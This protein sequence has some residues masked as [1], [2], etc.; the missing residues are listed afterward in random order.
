MKEIKSF[1]VLPFTGLSDHCCISMNI[2][3]NSNIYQTESQNGTPLA[4]KEVF[5]HPLT[6][7]YT[8]YN[9][10]KHIFKHNLL[11]DRNID[12]IGFMLAHQTELTTIAIDN[13][14]GIL[15]DALI[16]SSKKS[17][18]FRKVSNKIKP[19]R[20]KSKNW[21]TKE[22]K[23]R[24]TVLR[25]RSKALSSE[26]FSR[27]NRDLFVKARTAYKSTCRKAEREYRKSLTKQLLEIGKHD[28]K[29]FWNII[30]KMNNWGKQRSDPADNITPNRWLEHFRKLLNNTQM[31]VTAMTVEPTVTFEP[32]LDSKISLKE[33]QEALAELKT[34][35]A[36]GPD[37][38]LVEYLRV[39]AEAFE[40]TLL[41]L[42]NKIFS[43]YTYPSHWTVN[44]LKPI[45]K[46]GEK[47]DTDNF[48]GLAIGSAFAKLFSQ[49]LLKRLT[50][51]IDEKKLLSANQIGF[52]KGKSTSDHIFLL[53]TVI[54]KVVKKGKRKL[55][56]AFID[57]KKAYDTVDRD[58]L[59]KRLKSLGINGIFLKNIASMYE[60]T[61]YSIKLSKGYLAPLNSNLG[62]KQGCPLSPI[63]FNL[64]ID[65]IRYIF[66]EQ[67]DPIE[68]QGIH[69]SHFLYA[70]DLVIISN[71]GE[72]LQKSL[73]N[74]H[75]YSMK[76]SISIS[77][78][79]SKTMIFNLTGKLI[80]NYFTISGKPLEP[81]HTFCYLGFDFKA[82]GS[83]KYAAYVLHDKANKAM[84]SLFLAVAKFN[85][86]VKT[87]IKLFH[88]YIS[89]I[90]LYN[91]ENWSIL[92][93]KKIQNFSVE[94]IFHSIS[95][96]KADILHR[97]FL[98]YIIG[99]SKSCPNISVYGETNE[100]PLSLK[101][102]RLMINFWHRVTNLPEDT[103]VKKALLENIYLH[104]NWIK[105][106]EKLLGCLGLTD[107]I[108][109]PLT[110]RRR[111]ASA[112]Q[113]K[114]SDFWYRIHRD[115][116]SSRMQFYRSIK[117]ELKFEEYLLIPTFEYRKSIA[118][119][120]CS[121]HPLEIEQGRHRNIPRDSRICKLCPSGEVENE[122]HF[123]T[124]CTFFDRY[125]PKYDLQNI[126]DATA[127]VNNTEYNKLG[128]Y[129]FEAL[130]ERK[131]YMGWFDLV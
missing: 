31:N 56:V 26:P 74:L 120:R 28:P 78:K 79:K 11:L 116:T 1:T 67:C 65:D 44:F 43:D 19:R 124:K 42:I 130:G 126:D 114:F 105:T 22:C 76:K 99:L 36:P 73:D 104:T 59:L 51:F 107:V 41:N 87:S 127:F 23:A 53:Q 40:Y 24:R 113:I 63:L 46:K 30:D 111:A 18:A 29:S 64:Y 58:L 4:E 10:R 7:K 121:D 57:F 70:D 122:E 123:L 27:I 69:L 12:K 38:I 33:M 14:I 110:L 25:Q 49:I 77:I 112:M 32:T 48:R 131:K 5:I 39:F 9:N 20:H 6:Y 8:F 52:L 16:A 47:D 61:K 50:K 118:Q 60:K 83:V 98:K 15:N 91:A 13:C 3:I 45:F 95:D 109:N 68:L 37:G 86:P 92:T 17:F 119:I 101:G 128:R 102:F 66:D 85:I 115:G 81:V 89:P 97:N 106:V 96:T 71:T 35:K 72:G 82:S 108:D 88:T 2:M 117:N 75:N 55:F 103:L 129:L 62:L 90:V 80:K 54:E 84:R 21:F 34:G 100:T 125:K 94:S 93:D